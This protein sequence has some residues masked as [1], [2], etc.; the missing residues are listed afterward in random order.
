MPEFEVTN[1]LSSAPQPERPLLKAHKTLPRRR[2]VIPR[3]EIP[4]SDVEQSNGAAVALTPSLPLTPPRQI[5]EDDNTTTPDL[6]PRPPQPLNHDLAAQAVRIRQFSPPTPDTTPPRPRASTPKAKPPNPIQASISSRA[7]SF[8]TA[9]E[10]FSS[11]E[12]PESRSRSTHSLVQKN[13]QRPSPPKNSPR[14]NGFRV[15]SEAEEISPSSQGSRK[16]EQ[17]SDLDSFDGEWVHKHEGG[18]A[19]S[20]DCKSPRPPGNHANG[21][22]AETGHQHL[23][24]SLA[25]GRSL[26]DRVHESQDTAVSP[27]VEKFGEDIGWFLPEKEQQLMD[28]VNTW[29][30]SGGS[31]MSTI[32]AMVIDLSPQT[33][34]TLRHSGKKASLR[35]VS[36]S[37]RTS[38]QSSAESQ[39]RLVHKSARI[40]N[41]N[42]HSVASDTVSVT[43][44]QLPQKLEVI[45]VVVI[46][47][48]RSS[49]KSSASSSRNH[50]KTRSQGSGSRPTTAPDG[51]MG[52]MDM[53]MRQRKRNLS[54]SVHSTSR[55]SDKDSR[56][57]GFV[58]PPVPPRS[59][60]L[61]APTSRN[62]SRTTSLTSE[63][64]RRHTEEMNMKQP[65]SDPNASPRIILPEDR[66][67]SETLER[68]SLHQDDDAE[69]LR[70]PSQ[71]FTQASVVSS[72]PGPVEISEAT[73][74]TFFP[75]NNESLLLIDPN[76]QPESR[77]VQALRGRPL[78]APLDTQTPEQSPTPVNADSPLRNPRPPPKPP[79]FKVIP[80][81]PMDEVDRQLSGEEE[82]E[83][84]RSGRFARRLSSVRRALSARRSEPSTSWSASTRAARN[85]TAGKDIDSRLHPF[86]RPRG[87]WDDFGDSDD[88]RVEGHAEWDRKDEDDVF[89]SNSLGLPQKRVIFGGPLALARRISTKR[90]H[91][92]SQGRGLGFGI[93]RPRSPLQ[94]RVRFAS[95]FG[96]HMTLREL[97]QRLRRA[98]QLRQEE[99]WEAR[100]EKLKQS[101]GERTLIDPYSVCDQV[102]PATRTAGSDVFMSSAL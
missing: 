77:A 45:P 50:S 71:H 23:S 97:Q 8:K 102:V 27:S 60:S 72:S 100:R 82:E 54:D 26:R 17:P 28:R 41:R 32:E 65:P 62:N 76:Q 40:T 1:T 69:R 12:E 39:H 22:T 91:R 70:A 2:D 98:R 31:T 25:R 19:T 20:C 83:H 59:S 74:V 9:Q 49:L 61:S 33:R 93:M 24:S 79:A 94:R 95:R 55:I 3:I 35:S 15:R 10:A 73:A 5:Q 89:V 81:T 51:R 43:S 86:W 75:H 21:H 78:D 48:R 68:R 37:T 57:R 4:P 30:L 87:F 53:P 34:R 96:M 11:D 13:R 63:S 56:G 66:R 58:R 42:R 67:G 7:E 80:P 44:S 46:P 16:V 99:K 101:I 29:R 88:E 14:E 38:L 84:E 36:Q 47:E 92:S 6:K 90:S 18:S 52:S 64:L 85:H